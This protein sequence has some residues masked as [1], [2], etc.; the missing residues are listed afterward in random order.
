MSNFSSS[1][2]VRLFAMPQT[3]LLALPNSTGT[4]TMTTA[5]L[6]PHTKADFTPFNELIEADFMTGT[7]SE[8]AGILGRKGPGTVAI[9]VAMRPSGA[10][11]TAPDADGVLASIFGATAT[12]VASTSATYNLTDTIYPVAFFLFNRVATT[13][14]QIWAFGC[15]PT[16]ATLNIGGAGYLKLTANY[17]CVYV[18]YSDNFANEDT[19]AKAGYTA[20]PTEPS[21]PTVA[22]SIITPFAGTITIGGSSCPE[23]RSASL[24]IATGKDLRADGYLNAYPDAA[25]QGRRKVVLKSLKFADSDGAVLATVK[26]AAMNK[27][28]LDVVIA[29]GVTAGSIMTST[30]KAVQ[31][32]NATITQNGAAIDV[33]FADSTAHASA[34]G[35]TNDLIISCT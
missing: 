16:D 32:G 25:V 12:L 17:K 31:F 22:G 20:V 1:P 33:N 2:L 14:T 10:A 13:N 11:G 5:K 3:S 9:E 6:L 18:M 28:A 4:P 26:N 30:V 35:S 34:I 27:T 23:F 7:G 24:S 19:V 29:Q 15:V 8:L 21:S